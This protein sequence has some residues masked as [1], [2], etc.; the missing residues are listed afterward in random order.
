MVDHKAAINADNVSVIWSSII[1]GLNE[2]G[3]ANITA[4]IQTS[5][6]KAFAQSP[7]LKH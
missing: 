5:I 4:R 1:N 2:G 6:D 7:Y 3:T